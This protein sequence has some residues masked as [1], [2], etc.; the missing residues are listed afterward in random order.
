MNK[1]GNK[2][3]QKLCGKFFFWGKAV[4]STLLCHISAIAPQ[5]AAPTED[6]MKHTVQLFDYIATQEKAVLAYNAS[7]TKLAVHSDTRYHSEPKAR[8][9]VGGGYF[10]LFEET[11]V[12]GN[13]GTVLNIAHIIK[14]VMS[15]ATEAELAALYIMSMEV[16]YIRIILEEIGH[17]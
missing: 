5:S 11:T 1:E 3:I 17:K 15:S 10:F 12:P 2:F 4:E 6:I 13:N 8:S 7:D 9:R 14:H 16:F